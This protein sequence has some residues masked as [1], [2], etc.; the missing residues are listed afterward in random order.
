ME[1]ANFHERIDNKSGVIYAFYPEGTVTSYPADKADSTTY[2]INILRAQRL[3]Y[4]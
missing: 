3:S 4:D 1:F 2:K